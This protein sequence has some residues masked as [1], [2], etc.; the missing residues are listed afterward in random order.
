MY[1]LHFVFCIS[2]LV[3]C[4]TKPQE[5]SLHGIW[6][7]C[8]VQDGKG[9]VE[10]DKIF[11]EEFKEGRYV[12]QIEIINDSVLV[13]RFKKGSEKKWNETTGIYKLSSDKKKIITPKN[14]NSTTILLLTADSLKLQ[15][16][17]KDIQIYFRKNH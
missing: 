16:Y 2:C 5:I 15:I 12:D 8:R 1:K 6:Q 14:N 3:F 9:D 10:S 13:H 17:N 11:E 4:T 7:L